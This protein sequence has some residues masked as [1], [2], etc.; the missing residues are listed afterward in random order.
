MVDSYCEGYRKFPRHYRYT[1]EHSEEVI[2]KGR[3]SMAQ[4]WHYQEQD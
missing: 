4:Q 2:D 1:M 3:E